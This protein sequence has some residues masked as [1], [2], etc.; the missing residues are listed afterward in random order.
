M[1]SVEDEIRAWEIQSGPPSKLDG[2]AIKLVD[3]IIAAA[4]ATAAPSPTAIASLL[5]TN[6]GYVSEVLKRHGIRAAARMRT[7]D[8]EQAYYRD[9]GRTLT[10]RACLCCGHRFWSEGPHNRMCEPCRNLPSD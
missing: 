1:S 6:S 8:P 5:G 2:P 4:T 10:S 3:R 9:P 7:K